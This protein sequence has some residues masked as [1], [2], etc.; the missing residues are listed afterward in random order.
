VF[1]NHGK[2]DE[3]YPTRTK[4]PS[5]EIA[6][7]QNSIIKEKTCENIKKNLPFQLIVDIIV[8]YQR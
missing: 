5:K 8:Q 6:K 7:A 2:E 4:I 3:I 1:R